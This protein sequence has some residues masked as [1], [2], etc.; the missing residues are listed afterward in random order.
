MLKRAF[1]AAGQRFPAVVHPI[2]KV[3]YPHI[4]RSEVYVGHE[5]DTDRQ[6]VF[7][8]IY[9]DNLWHADESRSGAG[10]AF[11]Q[12]HHL[13]QAL[14]RLMQRLG[15]TTLLDAPCGD[16][17]WMRRVAFGPD[18]SYVGGDLVRPLIDD[19]TRN[20]GNDRRSF[21]VLD[22]VDD[23][24]PPCDVWLCRDVLFHLPNADVR[25]VLE[26]IDPS[27]CKYF[28]ST[29]YPWLDTNVDVK[30]GGF[31]FIN[32]ERPPFSLPPPEE[33]ID[34]FAFPEPPR[35][36]GLWRVEDIIARRRAAL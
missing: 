33:I 31:R 25:T 15:A 19:L 8:K 16:F 30:A 28:L 13:V 3:I 26:R 17:H 32:L 35:M 18:V 6:D 23:A 20:F 21:R 27:R 9:R 10:S 29:S 24:L 5:Y 14:P 11:A 22:I 36:L 2:W 12:T 1:L 7:E 4:R 34:D